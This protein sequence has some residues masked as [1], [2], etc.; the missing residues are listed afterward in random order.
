MSAEISAPTGPADFC[1]TDPEACREF[2][3]A[4]Y[5]FRL[6]IATLDTGA[7]LIHH[8]SS[9]G[10]FAI[11][12]MQLTAD[13]TYRTDPSHLLIVSQLT[14]TD[15]ILQ[16]SFGTDSDCFGPGDL[17]L[18]A[19]PGESMSG[20]IR[21]ARLR[22]V[23]L[24][25]EVMAT[26]ATAVSDPPG[27]PLHFTGPRP[28][29][30][31]SA[32]RWKHTVAFIADDLLTRP[33]SK[34]QPLVVSSAARLLAATVLT[35]FPNTLTS[36]DPDRCPEHGVASLPV[37]RAVAFIESHPEADIGLAEIAAAAHVSPRA[38][39]HAFRRHMDTTPTGYL[40][41]VR[42]AHAHQDLVAASPAGGVTVTSIAG[43]WGF[44][45]QGRFAALYRAAYGRTPRQTLRAP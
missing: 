11:D 45:H 27:R 2:L 30:A 8:R 33:E 21:Q 7:E 9:A 44:A 41:R 4:A 25:P 31:A 22:T 12:G 29:D 5:G 24:S 38:L 28:V 19:Q 42:L 36:C 16:H 43:R 26:A 35:A 34:V 39:Q 17:L 20:R 15:G 10:S 3:T 1:S 40:R 32:Q 23:L 13:F 18:A 37:R 14:G 6:W